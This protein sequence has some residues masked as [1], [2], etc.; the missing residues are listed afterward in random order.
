M[1]LTREVF[2]FRVIDDELWNA[3]YDRHLEVLA[4]EMEAATGLIKLEGIGPITATAVGDRRRGQGL[5]FFLIQRYDSGYQCGIELMK[6][7][8][9]T[10]R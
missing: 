6:G 4:K 5:R 1:V 7:L 9:I 2:V 3:F 10:R 8:K